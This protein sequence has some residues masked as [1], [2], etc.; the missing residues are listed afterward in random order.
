MQRQVLV[1]PG[2]GIGEQLLE[3]PAHGEHGRAGIDRPRRRRPPRASCRPVRPPAPARSP[4]Q[5][6]RARSQRGRQPADAGADHHDTLSVPSLK[7]C[8]LTATVRLGL[9]VLDRQAKLDTTRR[10]IGDGRHDADRALAASRVGRGREQPGCPPAARPPPCAT[11][12]SRAAPGSG[13]G[14]AWR[15]RPRAARTRPKLSD[16][17]AAAIELLH[18]A[19]LVHDDLPCFD[20]A[21]TAARPAQRARAF[22]EPL[23]VL[24]G[25]A[26]IVLAFQTLAPGCRRGAGAARRADQL[27]VGA[28]GRRA[29]RHRRRPGLGVRGRG[30]PRRVSARED[31]RPVRG[32]HGGRR[33]RGRGGSGAVAARWAS[34]SARRIR[35][36]T[37]SW[38]RPRAPKRIGKPVGQDAAHRPAERGRAARAAGAIDRLEELADRRGRRRAA[39]PRSERAAERTSGPRPCACCRRNWRGTPLERRHC[40]PAP[41]AT[42]GAG[43]ALPVER[44]R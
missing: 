22:G 37:T 28:L 29:L 42:G 9:T 13:R 26:L 20:D 40:A 16:A 8:P 2:A 34:G 7:E 32:R 18:C 33:R 36:P 38:T 5:P 39:L 31:R 24:A 17:A 3:H 14:C 10:R 1:E 21:A 15:S 11:P 12:C 6:W 4:A 23:A 43:P 19:S 41:P 25:D 44:G 27:T 35:S 30:R